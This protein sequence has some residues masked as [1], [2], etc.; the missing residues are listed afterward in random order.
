MD[1]N[2]FH[3][4]AMNNPSSLED[5]EKVFTSLYCLNL[6]KLKYRLTFSEN[7]DFSLVQNG[8]RVLSMVSLAH[9]H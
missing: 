4:D 6:S 3:M 9:H 7:P 8:P 2:L 5:T 1:E